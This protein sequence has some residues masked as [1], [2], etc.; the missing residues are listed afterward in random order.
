MQ[1]EESPEASSENSW[2]QF[3]QGLDNGTLVA[4]WDGG[5]DSG[6]VDTDEVCG[7]FGD[8]VADAAYQKLDYGSWAGEWASRGT[9]QKDTF[10]GRPVLTFEGEFENHCEYNDDEENYEMGQWAI[11]EA[12]CRI[13]SD[14][15]VVDRLPDTHSEDDI[16]DR[17]L[18]VFTYRDGAIPDEVAEDLENIR[19]EADAFIR[20]WHSDTSGNEYHKIQCHQFSP[21]AFLVEPVN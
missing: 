1:N 18:V 16:V 5:E 8:D 20:N 13:C 4:K 11:P 2:K 10:E 17:E 6:G 7:E 19:R 21:L 15:E 14:I 9:V 3:I 12:V